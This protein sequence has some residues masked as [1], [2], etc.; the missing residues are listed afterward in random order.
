[1]EPPAL[2]AAR[3]MRRRLAGGAGRC[4]GSQL[5]G[6]AAATAVRNRPSSRARG[7]AVKMAARAQRDDRGTCAGPHGFGVLLGLSSIIELRFNALAKP[8]EP[9]GVRW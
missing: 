3:M 7:E 2:P 9:G 5:A 6:C 4:A 8:G 1:M